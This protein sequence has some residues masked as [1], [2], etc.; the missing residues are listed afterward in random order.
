MEGLVLQ[1]VGFLSARSVVK[2]NVMT[3]VRD[4]DRTEL[5][6]RA[7]GEEEEGQKRGREKGR[8]K[9]YDA[10]IPLKDIPKAFRQAP[11]PKH[12]TTPQ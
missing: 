11:P 9:T 10:N 5:L 4:C 1:V 2:L 8:G 3:G 12:H 6:T 7:A